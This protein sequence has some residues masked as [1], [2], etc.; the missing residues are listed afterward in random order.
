MAAH[1]AY[2]IGAPDALVA[3]AEDLTVSWVN[4]AAERLFGWR[5]SDWYGAHG[6]QLVHPDDL[7]FVAVSLVSVAEKEVGSPIEVRIASATGWRLVELIGSWV[8]APEEAERQDGTDQPP[9]RVLLLSMRDLT[10]R[11]RWEVAASDVDTFRALVHNSSAVLL[12]VHP[13]G[14][15]DSASGALTRVLGHDPEVVQGMTFA[16]LVHPDD[17]HVVSDAMGRLRAGRAAAGTRES[18]E[19]R[20]LRRAGGDVPFELTLADLVDDPTVGGVVVSGHDITRL[21]AAQDALQHLALHDQLTGLPN[22]WALTRRL[23]DA[24]RQPRP[25]GRELAVVFVDLERFKPVNDLFGHDAGDQVLVEVARRLALLA[26]ANAFVARHGGDEFVLV[27]EVEAD[28]VALL[29]GRVEDAVDQPLH[30]TAGPAQVHASVGVVLAGPASTPD[31]LLAE[32]D[33]DMFVQKRSRRGGPV[34][35]VPVAR[36]RALAEDLGSALESDELVVH[37]QPIAALDDGQ[38]VAVEALVRWQHPELGLL[39]PAS[40]LPIVE[41]LG[42]SREVDALVLRTACAAVQAHHDRDLTLTVN[43]SPSHLTRPGFPDLVDEVLDETGLA[44]ERLWIEVTEHAVMERAA[45]GPASSLV[46]VFDRLAALGVGVA[47]DDFGTGYSSLSHLMALPVRGL[48][49][50]RSFVEGI[51]H[52]RRS[53]AM[54]EALVTLSTAMDLEVV[55]EGVERAPQVAALRDIGC[56]LGQGYLLGRPAPRLP[57]PGLRVVPRPDQARDARPAG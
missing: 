52:D 45:A 16:D 55:A 34:S 20:L 38:V 50:D 22:R 53:R 46:A 3:L 19:V 32:A 17:R 42:R 15:V 51:D 5:G 43:A 26:H 2:A 29:R 36:R 28:E 7:E 35:S 8:D 11:R 12:L 14:T 40:F 24:L 25:P 49:I 9:G 4:R 27:T 31:R 21:R 48:K 39:P 33:A 37:Y 56:R 47:I 41:D 6:L 44:P 54:V 30:L 1:D 10:E 13:D 57:R 18:V 23:A